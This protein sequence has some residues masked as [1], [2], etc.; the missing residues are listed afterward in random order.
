MSRDNDAVQFPISQLCMDC[1]HGEF[2]P[3]LSD[4]P[5]ACDYRC[6]LGAAADNDGYNCSMRLVAKGIELDREYMLLAKIG[7]RPFPNEE[8]NFIIAT[9]TLV[10]VDAD[11]ED[12]NDDSFIYHCYC[13][14]ER[15]TPEGVESFVENKGIF[16]VNN[17]GYIDP[18]AT[19]EWR[20][21]MRD[22][23]EN[24]MPVIQE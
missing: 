19:N 4:S 5:V 7:S 20:K 12:Y 2:I 11:P 14:K 21:E 8:G 3:S 9:E 23:V 6:K 13:F 1:V 16:V 24:K 15:P 22:F 10:D 17:K 18:D